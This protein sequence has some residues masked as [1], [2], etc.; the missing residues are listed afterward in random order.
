MG[1]QIEAQRCRPPRKIRVV[2]AQQTH[3]P[4]WNGAHGHQC[5]ERDAAAQE[6]RRLVDAEQPFAQILAHDR[7][8]QRPRI[9]RRGGLRL[10]RRERVM[11]RAQAAH[12]G[13]IVS[14]DREQRR[15]HRLQ[16]RPPDG[17]RGRFPQRARRGIQLADVGE[18]RGEHADGLAIDV[19][20]GQHAGERRGIRRQR[21][22][23][24]Q[25]L[26][27]ECPGV[28][29]LARGVAHRQ[30]AGVP[31]RA[32]AAPAHTHLLQPEAN[33]RQALT[34]HAE[35]ALHGGN[36]QQPHHF[37]DAPTG[38]DQIEQRE[39]SFDDC[40][41][42]T[43]AAIRYRVGDPAGIRRVAEYGRDVRRVGGDIGDHHHDIARRERGICAEPV[44]Q[45]IVQ[46]F[47]FAQR[48]VAH[49]NRQRCIRRGDR[50]SRNWIAQ[51]VGR[52]RPRAAAHPERK[53][54]GLDVRQ[55]CGGVGRREELVTFRQRPHCIDRGIDQVHKVAIQSAQARQQW[56]ARLV[57]ARWIDAGAWRAVG[58]AG[59]RLLSRAL[60]TQRQP[61]QRPLADDVGPVLPTWIGH[62]KLHVD[63]PGERA[64]QLQ[65]VW[66]RAAETEHRHARRH[67]AG[68]RR[69]LRTIAMEP[70][71]RVPEQCRPMPAVTDVTDQCAPQRWL[72][73]RIAEQRIGEQRAG[74]QLGL[75]SRFEARDPIPPVHQVLIEHI[76][77]PG[78]EL[79]APAVA[80]FGTSCQI[81]ANIGSQFGELRRVELRLQQPQHAPA[82]I[83]QIELR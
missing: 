70:H 39:Q 79:V 20:G 58:R 8:R 42:V 61:R 15:Q 26:K 7:Q 41:F 75:V 36:V 73:R 3:Q 16:P 59:I 25:P 17:G 65:Q 2:H 48:T 45:L 21:V 12:L 43:R 60:R 82:Q 80:G 83:R 78:R 72:P 37:G 38:A 57:V 1:Q 76:R 74:V 30:V 19:R 55:Q 47:D 13:R 52:Q 22:A 5:A 11:N 14:I 64:Q 6:G 50:H 67:R 27:A 28:R 56:I 24:Q 40:R 49:V 18:Q 53:N 81:G 29:L 68:Q 10:Q 44:Q 77:D 33:L 23:E 51:R 35:A 32:V 54:V 63:V 9:F 4:E 66:R 31:M 71:Q 62:V 46:H 34:L 69:R